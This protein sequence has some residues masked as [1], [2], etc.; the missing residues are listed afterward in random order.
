MNDDRMSSRWSGELTTAFATAVASRTDRVRVHTGGNTYGEEVPWSQINPDQTFAVYLQ[1]RRRRTRCVAFDLDASK[2][3]AVQDLCALEQVLGQAGLD[4]VTTRSGPSG[5]RHLFLPL[6]RLVPVD[7]RIE[8]AGQLQAR[9]PSLDVSTLADN[10]FAAIRPPG[11]PH[12]SGGRSEVD[13]DLDVALAILNRGNAPTGI[14]TLL[15]NLSVPLWRGELVTTFPLGR[16]ELQTMLGERY[17]VLSGDLPPSGKDTSSSA[18][19]C[20]VM[21]VMLRSGATWAQAAHALRG[22]ATER[23]QRQRRRQSWDSYLYDEYCRVTKFLAARPDF[24]GPTDARVFLHELREAA[25]RC[26][27]PGPKGTSELRVLTALIG[28]GLELGRI[29]FGISQRQLTERTGAMGRRTVGNALKRLDGVWLA[30]TPRRD[31]KPSTVRLRMPSAAQLHQRAIQHLTST[32]G[33]DMNGSR[34]QLGT[35]SVLHEA[36]GTCGLAARI[37]AVLSDEPLSRVQIAAALGYDSPSSLHRPLRHQLQPWELAEELDDGTWVRGPATLEQVADL[38]GRTGAVAQ[39]RAQ[40]LA[41]RQAYREW[42]GEP[43]TATAV[44]PR[45]GEVVPAPIRL[46]ESWADYWRHRANTPD[47]EGLRPTGTDAASGPE[48]DHR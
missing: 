8:L 26:R 34:V 45:T 48:P 23:V 37:Y 19:I 47:E 17:G 28:V 32:G 31:G 30:V 18:R 16:S 33:S 20:E 29:E 14:V 39:R 43:A 13:G 4:Y 41:E 10:E 5:G 36:F 21:R 1:D 27:W 42:R 9:L 3:D 7:A 15:R 38:R 12:R 35:G 22:L 2:G 44:D 11:A 24:T 25:A 6:Q 46:R 40:N